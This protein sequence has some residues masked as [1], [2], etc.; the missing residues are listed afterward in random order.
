MEELN[1]APP[2]AEGAGT[3][4][5]AATAV[6]D[7]HTARHT[8]ADGDG[9]GTARPASSM[10]Y[11]TLPPRELYVRW[12]F[13][14]ALLP[15]V[16]FSI[17]PWQ[18]DEAASEACRRALELRAARL[19]Q[20]EALAEAAAVSGEPLVRPMWWHAPTDPTCQWVA[21]Q[22]LL[23]NTTLVAP[24]LDAGERSRPI[25]LPAGR[26]LGRANQ[27]HVGPRWLVD[28]RVALDELATFELIVGA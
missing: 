21:D 13:A 9:N 2:A 7:E 19:P 15:A 14:N 25:Y 23:G 17:A 24:V 11:G 6:S 22:F 3:A 8:F 5:A 26:W 16:Q 4:G 10:F 1:T 12:C 27:V 20:L 18:Y 28:Y